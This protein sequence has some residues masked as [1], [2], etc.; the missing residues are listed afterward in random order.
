MIISCVFFKIKTQGSFF[1]KTR[2]GRKR[3]HSRRTDGNIDSDTQLGNGVAIQ[4]VDTA[5]R[6][7]GGLEER[8]GGIVGVGTDGG[9]AGGAS[10][11]AGDG[12]G[13][14]DTVAECQTKVDL[15]K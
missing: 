3:K 4:E 13:N 1:F 2:L 5:R 15:A 9:G 7:Y 10:G 12:N 6:A 14:I 8:N 11:I